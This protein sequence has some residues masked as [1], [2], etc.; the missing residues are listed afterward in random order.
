[1]GATVASDTFDVAAGHSTLG[2]LSWTVTAPAADTPVTRTAPARRIGRMETPDSAPAGGFTELTP[3]QAAVVV[4]PAHSIQ[5]AT[6]ADKSAAIAHLNLRPAQTVTGAAG[7][8]QRVLLE[9]EDGA[10]AGLRLSSGGFSPCGNADLEISIA[11][12]AKSQLALDTLSGVSDVGSTFESSAGRSISYNQQAAGVAGHSY[13]V[14][15]ADGSTATVTIDAVRNPSELDAKAR[16]LFRANATLVLKNMGDSS[17]AAAP[18][19]LTGV[20]GHATV[21]VTM[22]VQK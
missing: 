14:R 2:G 9:L 22:N 13:S 6:T 20:N 21:F 7:S 11:D 4:D 12:L 17:G 10:C 8:T 5:Q 3:L 18:G 15:L 1:N 16:A 19:D